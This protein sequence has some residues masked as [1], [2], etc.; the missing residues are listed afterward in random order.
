MTGVGIALRAAISTAIPVAV[1]WA[2][3]YV[4][5]GLIATLGAF[6]SRFGSGRPYLNRGVQLAVVAVALAG[7]V[8][9]GSWAAQVP[10]FGVAVISAVAVAAVWLCNALAVAPP[11]A[12]VFVLACAAGLG[13]SAAHLEPWQV[14][15]LVLAGGAVAWL[16]RMTGAPG[17]PRRPEHPAVAA[18]GAAVADYIE[19][20]GSPRE[21]VA[22]HRAATALHRSWNVL[23]NFQ[24]I[25]R[26][27]DDTLRDLRAANHALHVLFADSMSTARPRAGTPAMSACAKS[28]KPAP[29]DADTTRRI[30]GL[31]LAPETVSARDPDR[32]P[33]GTPN[34]V[35]L[36]T[37]PAGP[38]RHV[39]VALRRGRRDS[40]AR[41]ATSRSHWP[42][43]TCD[44]AAD[45]TEA[46]SCD[47]GRPHRRLIRW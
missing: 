8:A 22:R 11:G 43:S 37:R 41:R 13:V 18:A 2:A 6:T 24:P 16:A 30:A 46:V 42:R 31:E 17:G 20:V 23:I 3:G 27:A 25:D 35:I 33:L 1:G 21:Q 38:R 14:G 26:P 7:A 4:G 40:P 44:D 47:I 39:T 29:D 34:A 15:A 32:I 36:W 28:T 10:W 12:Y 45:A 5:S 19:A 9:V